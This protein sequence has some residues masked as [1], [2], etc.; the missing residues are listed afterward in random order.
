MDLNS[1]AEELIVGYHLV[2][3][4]E[5]PKVVGLK[6]T[7]HVQDVKTLLKTNMLENWT[8]IGDFLSDELLM[9][10]IQGQA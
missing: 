8:N 5:L 3:N 6:P 9:K 7:F 1:L 10:P 4:V 2:S